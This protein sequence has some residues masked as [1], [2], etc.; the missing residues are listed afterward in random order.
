MD[1]PIVAVSNP[2]GNSNSLQPSTSP[3]PSPAPSPP[4]PVIVKRPAL[5][6]TTEFD[7]ESQLFFNKISAKFFDGL[8]KLKVSFSNDQ[9]GEISYPQLGFLTKH[10]SV[11]YDMESK[12]ALLSG[13]Y[14]V[15]DSLQFKATHDVKE[16]QGV[17]SMIANID[18]S[19]KLELSSTVPSPGMPKATLR[20]P[21]GEISLEEKEKED[22][23]NVLSLG[24]ILKG[25]LL[26]GVCTAMY[27]DDDLKLR[28]AYKDQEMSFIPSISLP[29]NAVSVAFKRRFSPKD[30]LSYLYHFNSN[31]WNTVYKHAVGKDLKFKAGYDS[32]VRL[33]WAS[34]WVGDEEGKAKTAPMKMKVQFMLQVPQDDIRSSAIMFR[35]KKRW[36]I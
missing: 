35:V 34:L 6:V 33:G 11:L 29:S 15:A 19:Y 36:D 1:I 10:F 25:K 18:P 16:Q 28:Y 9:N 24:G 32:E 13:S 5:R 7:S 21:N 27:K 22:L 2:N 17:V 12:N 20:F 14:N 23:N 26:N 8:A 30:K 3:S 31:A 4:R